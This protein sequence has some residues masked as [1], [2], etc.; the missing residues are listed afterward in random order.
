MCEP[1]DVFEQAVG[2]EGEEQVCGPADCD[3]VVVVASALV[4][5]EHN[6]PDD[7]NGKDHDRI[8]VQ[9][10]VVGYRSGALIVYIQKMTDG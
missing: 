9:M 10:F 4:I 8:C 3:Q 6:C 7:R 2:E 5:G 1:C